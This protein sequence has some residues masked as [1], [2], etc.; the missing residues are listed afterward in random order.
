MIVPRIDGLPQQVLE[1]VPGGEDLRQPL[2]GDDL[3]VA[4]E[5]DALVDLDPEVTQTRPAARQR[6]EELRMGRDSCAAPH[7]LDS[8]SFIDVHVPT[9]LPQE[10]RG[11]ETRHRAADDYGAALAVV[12]P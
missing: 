8:R 9:D 3:A 1:P 4:V 12:S 7:E 10:R 11:E 6:F 5:R 2:L